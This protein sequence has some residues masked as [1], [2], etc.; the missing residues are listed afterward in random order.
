MAVLDQYGTEP[1]EA[2]TDRVHMALLKLSNGRKELLVRGVE[3]AKADYRDVLAYA[4]YP[5]AMAIPPLKSDGSN[6]REIGRARRADAEQYREWL[7]EP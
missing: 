3:A 2:E 7:N 6:A 4:E 1:H 5:A